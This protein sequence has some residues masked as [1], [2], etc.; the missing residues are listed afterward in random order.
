MT[1]KMIDEIVNTFVKDDAPK[2]VRDTIR[3]EVRKYYI[4]NAHEEK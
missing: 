4:F 1:E 2:W 3:E